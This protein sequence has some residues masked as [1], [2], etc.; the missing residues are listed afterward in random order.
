[1]QK[2]CLYPISFFI[3][4][5]LS[6]AVWAQQ[7]VQYKV[8]FPNAV[9][10]EAEIEITLTDLPPEVL[11]IKMA[12]T[13]PGR[14]AL[15]E[16]AKN[17]YN[18]QATDDAGHELN[19]YRPDPYRWH[20]TGHSGKVV[21]TYTL[22]ADQIDG[23]YASVDNRQAH[24]NIPATFMY[25]DQ[26]KFRPVEVS[27]NLSDHPEWKIATQLKN[28][29]E[30]QFWAPDL[31]Y[32]MDSPIQLGN[33]EERH[34]TSTSNGKDYDFSMVLHH[35]GSI[36][37]TDQ[38]TAM[39]KK[40]VE[41]EKAVFGELPDFDFGSYTFLVN[42]LSYADGD[43]ME[44]R[45]STVIS[46]N[47][48]LS[49]QIKRNISTVSHEFFHAWNVERIRPSSLEPFDFQQ[50][51]MSGE[52]WFAEGFTSYYTSLILCRAGI[53]T[54]EEYME[55][56][57]QTLNYVL[58]SPGNKIFSPVEMSYQAPF[59]D[60]AVS[61]DPVNRANT[62]IS[63]YSYGQVIGLALD[64]TLRSQHKNLTL[65]GFMHEMWQRYGK[66]ETPYTLT[67]LQTTLADYSK[68]PNFAKNFFDQHIT[69]TTLPDIKTLMEAVG[70]NLA[71][72]HPNSASLGTLKTE[73]TDS[74]LVVTSPV[75]KGS[76][77][78]E[79]GIEQGD[80][81]LSVNEEKLYLPAQL[82]SIQQQLQPG[83]TLKVHY[84]QRDVEKETII[85]LEQDQQLK[86]TI[87]PEVEENMSEL[88]DAWLGSKAG[89]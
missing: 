43:G 19:I 3:S 8:S 2:N 46:A 47:R 6:A 89:N 57:T 85:T 56:L 71:H 81:I 48:P 77:L 23:T 16:F 1:M 74:G 40:V 33:F 9:H 34:W 45:N 17:V 63:Y 80:L 29:G 64:L 53:I 73:P 68:D 50:A 4:L 7:P 55:G 11:E 38:F 26:L 35:D 76:P 10:H 54:Q 83:K 13:S 82:D 31:Y 75:H 67:D 78:Y 42:Y 70:I 88:R 44:H 87:Q 51:N 36:Q 28:V 27:I 69:G 62:F 37:E 52:L 86:L 61:V 22:F 66:P 84:Y 14:Y 72:A 41:E 20:I 24:L 18:V 79:A 65:D 39:A 30:N 25:T 15:H 59:V 21:L 12:R 5:F 32:F 49:T 58:L 60:A